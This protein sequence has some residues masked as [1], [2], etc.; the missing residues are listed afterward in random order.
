MLRLIRTKQKSFIVR[1]VFWVIIAAFIGTVFLVWGR[2]GDKGPTSGNAVLQINDSSISYEEYQSA[3]SNLYNLYRGIYRDSFTP[4]LEKQLNLPQQAI[5]QLI[6]QALLMQEAE[7]SG[8]EISENELV[9]AIAQISSFQENGKFS[10]DRY[11]QVLNYERMKPEQFEAG[12]RRQMLVDKLRTQLQQGISVS[13]EEVEE[14]YRK[15]NDKIN[16]NFVRLLPASFEN[17]VKVTEES[18]QNYFDAQQEDFR[19]PERIAL[20]Y[21]QFDPARYE[22]EITSFSDEEISRYYR[23]NLDLF[24]IK[25]QAKASHI[26][27]KVD[28]DADDTQKKVRR[29]LAASILQQINEGKDFATLARANSDDPGSAAN[30]GEL[31]YFGRGTM[32]APFE[33][34]AFAMKPGEISDIVET[35]FGY[36]IIKLEEYIEAGVKSPA[37]AIDEVKKGLR[38]EK[39]RQLAYEKAMDAYN[40]NRKTGD[41]DAAAKTNDLGIKETGL[42][43][44]SDAIDGIGRE[45]DITAAAFSLK[46]GELARPVQTTQG[47]FLFTI[48]ERQQSRIPELKEV[49]AAV[50]TAYRKAQAGDL[51]KEA[52]D[53]LLT[54]ALDKKSLKRAAKTAGFQL[55]ETGLFS[56]SYG[57]F[58]PRI[59]SSQE[60]AAA[61]FALESEKPL[62]KV[63]FRQGESYILISLKQTEK[64]DLEK[65]DVTERKKIED[66]LLSQKKET[67]VNDLLKKLRDTAQITI[68]PSL[69]S[70][71]ARR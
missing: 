17:K 7:R 39:A 22:K 29:A 52:A 47:V 46:E 6:S 41:L 3:Y 37:E 53:K 61:A 31:G 60:L 45:A 19:Q 18:L 57:A 8:L 1:I 4:Q 43:D 34:A 56:S 2:G 33:K 15:E 21:L 40:I 69:D 23:R 51:A 28:K 25:E 50:E 16:L 54:A 35:D 11:V 58:V 14:S 44:R 63:V 64:A 71:L 27:I 5:E 30:G 67:V 68:D 13:K 49:R 10:R 62:G 36:H 24:E 66:R 42:F 65:L 12:Q 70:E 38:I 9:A 20:R 59:G 26:L 55:E 32:V 48:K